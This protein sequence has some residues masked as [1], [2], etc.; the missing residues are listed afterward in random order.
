MS[1]PNFTTTYQYKIYQRVLIITL[2][3]SPKNNKNNKI[4][5]T[6][7]Y[8]NKVVCIYGNQ[9]Q[10]IENCNISFPDLPS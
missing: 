6:F 7:S 3:I 10:R 8:A 2:K 4:Y 1:L 9:K 5:F